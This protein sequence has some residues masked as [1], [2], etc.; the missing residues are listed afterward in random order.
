MVKEEIRTGTRR[1]EFQERAIKEAMAEGNKKKARRIKHVQRAEAI[2]QV[3]KKC[4]AARGLYN[5]G[6][7]S[8][9]VVPEDSMEG[10]KTCQVWK[11]L[12]DPQEVIQAINGRLQVY[13]GQAKDCT[14]TTPPLDV[15]MDFDACC[16]KA[17]AILNGTFNTQGL[18]QE[19]Q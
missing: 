18:D 12:E 4:T 2:S 17:E 8:H 6:G 19:A 10:P 13:F 14:W 15:T 9:V 3:W 5:T 1:Q 11:K 7:I 16:K